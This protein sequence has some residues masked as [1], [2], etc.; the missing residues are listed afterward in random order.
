M[1]TVWTVWVLVV[2]NGHAAADGAVWTFQ[3]F[4]SEAQCALVARMVD[5]HGGGARA[6]C[7]HK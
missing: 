2:L 6:W 1:G 4:N 7:L 5:D 3:E